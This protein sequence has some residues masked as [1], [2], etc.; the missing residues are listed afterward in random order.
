MYI[1]SVQSGQSSFLSVCQLSSDFERKE[2]FRTDCYSVLLSE[3]SILK[4]SQNRARYFVAW[5]SLS[6]DSLV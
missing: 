3:I 6:L 4:F 2:I 1:R 5:I